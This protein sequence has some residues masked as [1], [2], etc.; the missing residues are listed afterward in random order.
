MIK[1]SLSQWP[2]IAGALSV[3]IGYIVLYFLVSFLFGL[4]VK[5]IDHSLKLFSLFP[6]VHLVNRLG[7]AI[8]GLIEGMLLLSVILFIANAIPTK[9]FSEPLKKSSLAPVVKDMSGIIRP[10]LPE[11]PSFDMHMFNQKSSGLE[12]LSG[13]KL[14]NLDLKNFNQK[15]LSSFE[16]ILKKFEEEQKPQK[17]K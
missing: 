8:V 13:L 3:A 12:G 16:D 10:L 6:L 9:E 14:D 4:L 7:G 17:K 1:P 15:D 5:L 11:M 2:L